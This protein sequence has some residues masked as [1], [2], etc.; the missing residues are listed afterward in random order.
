[1]RSLLVPLLQSLKG[2]HVFWHFQDSDCSSCGCLYKLGFFFVSILTTRAQQLPVILG[3]LTLGHSHIN[4]ACWGP[5]VHKWDVLWAIW[6]DIAVAARK[7]EYDCPPNL[8]PREE[9]TPDMNRPRAIYQLL[10]STAGSL[11]FGDS[12]YTHV[13]YTVYH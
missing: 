6:C 4:D 3:P 10:E 11:I 8:K 5:K 9:G 1:M 2:I 7:L 13:L 12:P